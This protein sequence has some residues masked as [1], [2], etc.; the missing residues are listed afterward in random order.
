MGTTVLTVSRQYG[1]YRSS[2]SR[3]RTMRTRSI[4][5]M[6]VERIPTWWS[7]LVGFVKQ[8][9]LTMNQNSGV[10]PVLVTPEL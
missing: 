3:A 10:Q 9:W 2:S 7:R 5:R 1:P 4:R 6:N 8:Y